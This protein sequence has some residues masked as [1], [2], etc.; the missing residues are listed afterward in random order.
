MK[1]KQFIVLTTVVTLSMPFTASAEEGVKLEEVVVTATKTE[2]KIEEVPVSVT[3]IT[4]EDIQQKGI[5]SDLSDALLN[6]A[7]VDISRNTPTGPAGISIRG[8]GS[9]AR[10][11]LLI[12]GQP[13]DLLQYAGQHPLQMIDPNDVER[14]EIVRGAGSALYGANAMGGVVNIITKKGQGENKTNITLGYDSLKSPLATFS[15][16]GS[17]GRFNYNLNGRYFDTEG[18]KVIPKQPDSGWPSSGAKNDSWRDAFIGAKLGYEISKDSDISLSSNYLDNKSDTYGFETSNSVKE[19]FENLE[20]KHRTSDLYSYVLNLNYRR[21]DAEFKWDHTDTPPVS[22]EKT[23]K[24]R[25]EIKNQFDFS[26]QNRAIL[27]LDYGLEIV[28]NIGKTATG[29]LDNAAKSKTQD[30]GI[31]L[32]DE[33]NFSKRLFV[34]LGGRYDAFRYNDTEFVDYSAS[35]AITSD[36]N[37][38]Y[39]TFNPRGGVKY[40]ASDYTYLRASAGTGFRPP[41]ASDMMR[42]TSWGLPNPDLK[43]EKSVTYD[44]GV[45]QAFNFGLTA[46]VTGYY[47]K[48]TDAITWF[49]QPSGMWQPQNVGEAELKGV[50]VELKQEFS[51]NWSS[52]L[53]YTYNDSKVTRQPND[54]TV[55]GK[56]MPNTPLNKVGAG[57]IYDLP[58]VFTG[59]IEGRYYDEQFIDPNNTDIDKLPSYFVAD[60]KFT[61]H[62]PMGKNVM[63]ITAGVNNIFDKEYSRFRQGWLEEPRVVYAQVG[64]NF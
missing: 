25:G 59:R 33:F 60:C 58:K 55:E 61:Y 43:P 32:Q 64:Y 49:A 10:S 37:K 30:T 8:F 18:Y 15:T 63:D 21:H 12:D 3:V 1:Y 27:G 26:S 17:A 29:A 44:V 23:E 48:L 38:S 5:L 6:E 16:N 4:K 54:P 51:S 28:D 35:P 19:S 13:A 24:Y 7:G 31:Y 45:D 36:G 47:G 22:T 46:S 56:R 2:K 57:L 52:Y 20:Y 50:E 14:I 62:Q 41:Q 53:N 9:F 40:K 34:T 39:D 11:A 42:K